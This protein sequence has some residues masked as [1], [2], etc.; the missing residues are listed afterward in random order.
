MYKRSASITNTVGIL[1]LFHSLKSQNITQIGGQY[2]KPP[3]FEKRHV[4]AYLNPRMHTKCQAKMAAISKTK[5]N[6]DAY[7]DFIDSLPTSHDSDWIV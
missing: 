6:E 5:R 4:Y 2:F 7:I 1:W 3:W